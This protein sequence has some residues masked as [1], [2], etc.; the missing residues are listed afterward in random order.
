MTSGTRRS[1]TAA[2][3]AGAGCLGP[4]GWLGSWAGRTSRE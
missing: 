3:G 4:V 1:A 2:E